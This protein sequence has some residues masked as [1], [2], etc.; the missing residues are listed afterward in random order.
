MWRI[1]VNYRDLNKAIKKDRFP[2]PFIHHPRWNYKEEIIL[3]PRWIYWIQSNLDV[4]MKS[5]RVNFG[6]EA[7]VLLYKY[8]NSP[9]IVVS[10]CIVI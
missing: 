1:Y 2:L 7:Q 3:M 4:G 6:V 5:P 9:Q 8:V 10:E